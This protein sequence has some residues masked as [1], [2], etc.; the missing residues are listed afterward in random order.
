ML[1]IYF[2][3][4]FDINLDVI[5]VVCWQASLLTMASAHMTR[6]MEFVQGCVNSQALKWGIGLCDFKLL[7]F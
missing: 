1:Q 4:V 3:A 7:H 5:K 6:S 2:P